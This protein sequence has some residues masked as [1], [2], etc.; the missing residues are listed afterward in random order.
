[1]P[2]E[3]FPGGKMAM[4]NIKVAGISNFRLHKSTVEL[5]KN[6]HGSCHLSF[7]RLVITGNYTLKALLQT[8]KGPFTI[9]MSG[10]TV[11]GAAKFKTSR[12]GKLRTEDIDALLDVGEKSFSFENAGML[13]GIIKGILHS[14]SVSFHF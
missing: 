4:V 9:V 13:D 8:K 2:E 14:D 12:E 1:V 7:E 5:D 6:V 11:K 3:S 10:V